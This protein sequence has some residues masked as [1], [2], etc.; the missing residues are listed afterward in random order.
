MQVARLAG[1]SQV[2]A[3]AAGNAARDRTL[4]ATGALSQQQ[5]N[6]YQT[7]EQ[8]IKARVEAAEAVLAAQQVCG[9]NTH[10]LEP[11]DGVIS[12]RTATMGNVVASGIEPFRLI[13]QARLEWRAEFTSTE[14]GRT[15]VGTPTFVV[16]I[17]QMHGAT[18]E[19]GDGIE[20]RGF[21]IKIV[22]PVPEP[23]KGERS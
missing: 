8:T 14:L 17:A 11:D 16:S 9:R 19:T 4:Q 12:A 15:A 5:I 18:I 23:N 10:V 22:F 7:T 3:D 1:R 20:G 2:P 6:Q 21:A 13:R